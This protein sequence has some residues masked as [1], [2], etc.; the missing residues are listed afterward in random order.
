MA[1]KPSTAGRRPSTAG[2]FGPV[3]QPELVRSARMIMRMHPDLVDILDLRAAEKSMSRSKLIESVLLGY[4]QSD[5]RNPK[6]T[7]IGKIDDRA[8][9]PLATREANPHRYAE[10][11]ARFVTGHTVLF[12]APPPTD[13]ADEE[14]RFWSP[15]SDD[16]NPPEEVVETVRTKARKK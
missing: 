13:W 8:P 4:L 7:T 6:L 14:E 2:R 5:P 16:P 15:V 12:G 9:T 1:N 10:R 11:W 3:A